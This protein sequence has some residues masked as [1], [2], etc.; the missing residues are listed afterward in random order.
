LCP[1]SGG[2]DTQLIARKAKNNKQQTQVCQSPHR[3]PRN[4]LQALIQIAGMSVGACTGFYHGNVKELIEDV[5][6]LKP[7]IFIG[8]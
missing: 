4:V 7:T 6:E 3:K 5:A 2:I 8:E 1:L